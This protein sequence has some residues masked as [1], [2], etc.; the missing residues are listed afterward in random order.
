MFID[1]DKQAIIDCLNR[2]QPGIGSSLV[3]ITPD[4]REL[5]Q[6]GTREN[7]LYGSDFYTKALESEES[8]GIIE[9]VKYKGQKSL[10]MYRKIDDTG[11]LICVLI[12][13]SIVT[14]QVSQIRWVVGSGAFISCL[15]ALTVA[16]IISSGIHKTVK[17]MI[18]NMHL[19]SQGNMEVR[20]KLT[21][22][23]E[24]AQISQHMNTMLDSMT[25]LLA[26]V[27][28]V[29]IKVSDSANKINNSSVSIKESTLYISDAMNDIAKGLS[30]QADDTISCCGQLDALA[31]SISEVAEHSENIRGITSNT[32]IYIENSRN[33]INS[34]KEKAA[35]TSHITYSIIG[36][37][38]NLRIKSSKIGNIIQTVYDIADETSLLSLNAS[39]EAARAGAQGR[40]FQVIAEQIKKLADQSMTATKEIGIIS[41]DISDT[42]S[43]VV[44]T[45]SK[46]EKTISRQ[47]DAVDGVLLTFTDMI[48]QLGDLMEKVTLITQSA[49]SMNN[50]KDEA[51]R[52]MGNISDVTQLAVNEVV[53]VNGKTVHQGAEVK[54][55]SEVSK[56]M[57]K[58]VKELETSLKQF[59]LGS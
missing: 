24:L 57:E 49:T 40:G 46:A 11:C 26:D 17:H 42:T 55:L 38:E 16:L 43:Q 5:Y 33:A 41:N 25:L 36:D 10:F 35:E 54:K 13:N 2:I 32:E 12:P 45:A 34:L 58:Q 7:L 27:K 23:S 44:E 3:F 15:I 19:I 22:K 6:D 47:E 50:Q 37:I 4:G 48:K 21:G 51:L 53:N 18:K 30:S 14:D 56:E 28:K 8:Q 59:N 9:N 39:I 1:I 31:N 20:M 29:S 52:N